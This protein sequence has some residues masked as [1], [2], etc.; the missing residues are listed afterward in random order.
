M[1]VGFPY[2]GTDKEGQ[3]MKLFIL[4]LNK[5]NTL[6]PLFESMM[7]AGISGATVLDSTGMMRVLADDEHADYPMLGLLRHVY[8]PERRASKTVFVVLEDEQVPVLTDIA[9]RVTGG[10][11]KPDTGIAFTVPVDFMKGLSKPHV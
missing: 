2:T 5:T 9:D 6:E 10:L 3:M 1:I 8:S 11:D 4:V 7:K